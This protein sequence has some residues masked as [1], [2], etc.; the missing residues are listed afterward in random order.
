MKKHEPIPILGQFLSHS[1]KLSKLL[2]N[3]LYHWPVF[4]ILHWPCRHIKVLRCEHVKELGLLGQSVFPEICYLLVQPDF[5][6]IYCLRCPRPFELKNEIVFSTVELVSVLHN[7]VRL[8]TVKGICSGRVCY[9]Y[10][11]LIP[12]R[13]IESAQGVD[14]PELMRE[15]FCT[16][17][18]PIGVYCS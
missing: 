13:E 6:I 18:R 14:K 17:F 16:D 7:R 11:I 12:E 2:L 3:P 5:L 1:Q 15:K 9:Q 10:I 4:R 8:V